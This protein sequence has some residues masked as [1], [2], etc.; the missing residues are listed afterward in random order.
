MPRRFAA[1]AFVA[2][3]APTLN[4]AH[5]Q[6]MRLVDLADTGAAPEIAIVPTGSQPAPAVTPTPAPESHTESPLSP[7][8][9]SGE[10]LGQPQVLE[11]PAHVDFASAGSDWWTIGGGAAVGRNTHIDGNVYGAWSHFVADDVE[12]AAE[13]GAWYYDQEGDDAAGINPNVVFRWHFVHEHDYTIYADIGIGV[14]VATD[15]VPYDGTSFD[16]TPRA[17]VGATFA[18]NDA[19]DE[20]LVVG[21]RWAHVSNARIHGDD[22]NPGIDTIM[23]YSGFQFPF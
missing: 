9:T 14:L 8:F 5:A 16:F 15:N 4:V 22:N 6:T 11:S 3:L 10:P 21:L 13:L 1:A 18:L 23:L 17:G 12:F 20:R 19:G 2:G 7:I